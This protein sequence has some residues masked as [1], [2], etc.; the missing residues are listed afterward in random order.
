M[1][2]KLRIAPYLRK[3]Y[4]F[5]LRCPGCGA[6]APFRV[7]RH[8]TEL[9]LFGFPVLTLHRSHDAVCS[10]CGRHYRLEAG[11]V[12]LLLSKRRQAYKAGYFL[13]LPR[14]RKR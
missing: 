10:A 2:L 5:T 14:R 9:E 8:G 13:T 12:A 6:A 7:V 1:R 4:T 11:D 3:T